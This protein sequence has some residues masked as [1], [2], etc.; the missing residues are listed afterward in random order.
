MVSVAATSYG[1]TNATV[2]V[3]REKKLPIW[4]FY[5]GGDNPGV[6]KQNRSLNAALHSAG[7]DYRVTEY[8]RPGH[9]TWN[10]AYRDP[11]M[12]RWLLTKSRPINQATLTY[13]PINSPAALEPIQRS[14]SPRPASG[15]GAGGEG[16]SATPLVEGETTS[17]QSQAPSSNAMATNLKLSFKERQDFDLVFEATLAEPVYLILDSGGLSEPV[18]SHRLCVARPDQIVPRTTAQDEPL[19]LTGS[20]AIRAGQWNTVSVSRSGEAVTASVNGWPIWSLPDGAAEFTQLSI[21][22]ARSG[23]MDVSEEPQSTAAFRRL[24]YR[25][26]SAKSEPVIVEAITPSEIEATAMRTNRERIKPST[27]ELLQA[28]SQ[29]AIGEHITWSRQSASEFV[30]SFADSDF[31]RRVEVATDQTYFA[32]QRIDDD[33][34][35]MNLAFARGDEAS[36][37]QF[38]PYML[39][40]P[41]APSDFATA[42]AN[43]FANRQPRQRNVK[44]FQRWIKANESIDFLDCGDH[45][46]SKAVRRSN[47]LDDPASWARLSPEF[48]PT[49]QIDS[50]HQS[51]ALLSLGRIDIE[52]FDVDITN[53]QQVAS[54]QF[55]A[56]HKCEV[57]EEVHPDDDRYIRRFWIDL[58]AGGLIRCYYGKVITADE[59]IEFEYGRPLPPMFGDVCIE[60]NYDESNNPAGWTIVNGQSKEAP[61][62]FVDVASAQTDGETPANSTDSSEQCFN[63]P[64]VWVVDKVEKQQYV[65]MDSGER[66]RIRSAFVPSVRHL[67]QTGSNYPFS[68]TSVA[69]I[70]ACLAGLVMMGIGFRRYRTP[71]TT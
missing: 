3:L 60:I 27:I 8:D 58:D 29:Q 20:F 6:V 67:T 69:R 54:D 48:D 13:Q 24:R 66:Q 18:S 59:S 38:R 34:A 9:D 12:Y 44:T 21:Q 52:P 26:D 17:P 46:L 5:N 33:P 55:V 57:F 50:L 40:M 42:I 64:D 25:M 49:D 36:V 23:Q 37:V 14:G 15:R 2:D 4:L 35:R 28:R 62:R 11:A 19:D 10:Y 16:L 22:H 32:S 41:E 71:T 45:G 7:C 53:L 63:E 43:G 31:E 61:I 68:T 1:D 30:R 56:G 47:L 51:A 70:A 39:N 65:T